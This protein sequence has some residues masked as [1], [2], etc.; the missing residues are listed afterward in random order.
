MNFRSQ[1]RAFLIQAAALARAD[2]LAFRVQGLKGRSLALVVG[3]H[4]TPASLEAQ[5][6]E[7]LEFASRHFTITSL[8]DFAKL[9]ES[10]SKAA[11]SAKPPVLFTFDD[12]R[13]S[14]YTV[15]APLLESF[16]GRGVFFVVPAFAECAAGEALTFYRSRI[17]PDS[18][19]G[20]EEREDW[21]DESQPDRG[22]GG[23]RPCHR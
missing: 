18:R 1:A 14:N 2:E 20:D 17:N 8:E 22:I 10:H 4:E 16:G 11:A 21:T 23:S 3:V 7:Q 12:G 13:E 9:W 19:P 5:F 15:A 6:P